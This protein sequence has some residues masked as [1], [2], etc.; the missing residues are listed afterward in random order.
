MKFCLKIFASRCA[1][2]GAAGWPAVPA[3]VRPQ[4]HPADSVSG[5]GAEAHE[6][7]PSTEKEQRQTPCLNSTG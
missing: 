1:R 3:R 5:T 7:G 6:P 2:L 4:H